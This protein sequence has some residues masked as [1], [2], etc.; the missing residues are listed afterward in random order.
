MTT[1]SLLYDDC[2]YAVSRLYLCCMTTVSLLY[3]DCIY[4]VSRLYPLLQ[5]DQT[6]LSSGCSTS[7]GS[8]GYGSQSTVV[9]ETGYTDG[10]CRGV[11]LGGELGGLG[12]K[13]LGRG[14]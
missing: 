3:H 1:V 2:I 14:F 5:E 10:G 12:G 4:A 7:D 11:V 8:S 6:G 9:G 13:V